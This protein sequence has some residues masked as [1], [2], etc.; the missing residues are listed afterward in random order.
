[1]ESM[2]CAD[3]HPV[4]NGAHGGVRA[5]A[6]RECRVVRFRSAA[7]SADPWE[8][9]GTLFEDYRLIGRLDT[10]RAPAA[11]VLAYRPRRPEDASALAVTP[12]HRW[13]KAADRLW[14]CHDGSLLLLAHESAYAS[15]VVGA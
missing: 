13:F 4:S 9:L 1:M 12:P 14:M 11:E 2:E 7:G 5:G 15:R 8:A 3:R 6:C 10:I